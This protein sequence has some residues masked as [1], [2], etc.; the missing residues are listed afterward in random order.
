MTP[1]EKI[2]KMSFTDPL[3]HKLEL[4]VE[5]QDLIEEVNLLRGF[6]NDTLKFTPQVI[7]ELLSRIKE[8]EKPQPPIEFAYSK[9]GTK[10]FCIQGDK[11]VD[12]IDLRSFPKDDETL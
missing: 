8:L 3:G 11:L 10:M 7:R 1:E 2:M 9:C 12:T 5:Y 4:C 6:Y